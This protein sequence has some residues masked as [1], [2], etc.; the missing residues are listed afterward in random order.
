MNKHFISLSLMLCL[1]IAVFGSLQLSADYVM[2][3]SGIYLYK[4]ESESISKNIDSLSLS[5]SI[6]IFGTYDYTFDFEHII[7]PYVIRSDASIDDYNR[8]IVALGQ[9]FVPALDSSNKFIGYA[10]IR[11]NN[12]GKWEIVGGVV[13]NSYNKLYELLSGKTLMDIGISYQSSVFITDPFFGDMAILTKADGEEAVFDCS[14]YIQNTPEGISAQSADSYL[15]TGAEK[16]RHI[17]SLVMTVNDQ[18]QPSEAGI[19]DSDDDGMLVA[20]ET[21]VTDG[22]EDTVYGEETEIEDPDPYETQGQYQNTSP[23][24][25]DYTL[26]EGAEDNPPTG[27]GLSVLPAV[28]AVGLA[29]ILAVSKTKTRGF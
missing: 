16:D 3:D 2:P 11:S 1:I 19:F 25:L 10:E 18:G 24:D 20:G 26:S 21:W 5:D 15:K 6:F 12:E 29:G 14:G 17:D 22:D 28:L 27:I 4:S 23:E 13:G 7:S 9:Y 8:E